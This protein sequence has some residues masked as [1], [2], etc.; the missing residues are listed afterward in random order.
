MSDV[1]APEP[2]YSGAELVVAVIGVVDNTSCG[3]RNGGANAAGLKP[4]C[5][6]YQYEGQ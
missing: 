3:H 2:R 1:S 6:G 4:N 5:E